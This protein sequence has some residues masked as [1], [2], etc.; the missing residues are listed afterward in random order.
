MV[1]M[2]VAGLHMRGVQ[3]GR[4][5]HPCKISSMCNRQVLQQAVHMFAEVA[6]L[7]CW[8]TGLQALLTPSSNSS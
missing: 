3:P 7:A 6:Y 4:C 1:W 5:S 2:S 8:M